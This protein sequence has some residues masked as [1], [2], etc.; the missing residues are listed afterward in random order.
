MH[1]TSAHAA[2][3]DLTMKWRTHSPL[4][5]PKAA[6]PRHMVGRVGATYI[7]LYEARLKA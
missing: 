3:R 7:N 5:A 6:K 4:P 2:M 1:H